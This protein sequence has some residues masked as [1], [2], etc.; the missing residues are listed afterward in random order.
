[1]LPR[2]ARCVLSRLRCNGHILFLGYLSR[3]GR[4]Q[5]PSCSACGHF[6]SHSALSSYGLFA[7][8][9][10]WRLSVPL[11]PLAQTLGSCPASGAP[12][13]S[14][15][16]PSLERGRVTNNN[17]HN[18]NHSEIQLLIFDDLYAGFKLY[19]QIAVMYMPLLRIKT[20]I[21]QDLKV[22]R[23]YLLIMVVGWLIKFDNL[24]DFILLFHIR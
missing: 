12:W 8:L 4:I 22:R 23:C 7:P 11:R 9:T 20:H 1:M 3:I 15:M 21:G 2:H 10:L 24:S 5:N 14:A 6:S 18:E 19:L 13:S 16:P 17:M